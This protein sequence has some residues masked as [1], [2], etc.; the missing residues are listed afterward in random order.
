MVG[1]LLQI[2]PFLL[3]AFASSPMKKLKLTRLVFAAY[4]SV[5]A[6]GLCPGRLVA[7]DDMPQPGP[8]FTVNTIDEHDDGV[9]GEEDCTLHEAVAAANADGDA[10]D[11]VFING[12]TGTIMTDGF[13]GLLIQN[14]LTITGPGARLLT[15]SGNHATRVF[16][17]GF[18]EAEIDSVTIADGS[19]IEGA[20]V[21][22]GQ[23]TVT[24]CTVIGN[25]ATDGSSGGGVHGEDGSALILKNCTFCGNTAEGSGGAVFGFA[26]T[27]TNCTFNNNSGA[28]GG[29]L[30]IVGNEGSSLI[31]CTITDNHTTETDLLA[32][33]GVIYNGNTLQVA[34]SLIA[35]NTIGD[36]TPGD[37][38]GT[39]VSAGY[40]LIGAMDPP[41]SGFTDGIN[42]DH[43]GTTANPLDPGLDPAGL[44]NNGGPTDTIALL[45]ETL[46]VD[47]GDP[48][49]APER[50]ERDYDR[51]DLPDI[52]AF[53]FAGTIPRTL[54]N[55][56][57]RL[58][59]QT[60]DNVLI[61][62]FIVTGTH[63]KEVLLRAIGPSLP[64][65]GNL[66]NPFL[67]LHDSTGATIATNE[68]WQTNSNQQ[69]IIDTG[70]PP[71]NPLE[72][73]LLMT[74]NPGA[75]TAIVT[76]A[77]NETGIGLVEAYDLDR[78]TDSKLANISTRGF[79]Q[80]G[81]NVMIGGFIVLGSKDQDV[82]IRAIG[83]SLPVNNALADPVL[84]LHDSN[85]ATL[86][87]NDNWR[88]TQETEIAATGIP[89]TDAVESAI[90]A[91]LSP[92]AYTAIVRGAG[93]TT[94]IALV[95]SY[96]LN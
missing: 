70:I 92:G 28:F 53:E 24:N 86:A 84:E 18:T 88:D 31:A 36:G 62:G 57:T 55:I 91:T 80:A 19:G 82:L 46:A 45:P 85:G 64:L 16:F 30:D 69:A 12:L 61:G 47:A 6:A 29:A 65:E 15:I 68:D 90:L 34:N 60:G 50:D 33:G 5:L 27:A 9:C 78:T 8:T 81:D 2:D 96:G 71:S 89:P 54:A 51:A 25:A 94:G 3:A 52:G 48:V 32:A 83:P 77:N 37:V 67:E 43:V 74:L 4:L 56:S 40:N 35:G 41:S 10:N 17:V 7:A 93:D 22:F 44:E 73:A 1:A 76:G 49:N 21:T 87:V 66:A 95:E 20:V 39:F 38:F 58:L 13:D 14:P 72:S 79:V 11:I 63:S 23:L 42:H 26:V 59:V 75:Y